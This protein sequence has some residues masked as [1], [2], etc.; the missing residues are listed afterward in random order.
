MAKTRAET[1]ERLRAGHDIRCSVATDVATWVLAEPSTMHRLA[2]EDEQWWNGDDEGEGPLAAALRAGRVVGVHTNADGT[3]HVR[4]T[5][6]SLT[7]REARV[8]SDE[9]TMRLVVEEG[10]L[11]LCDPSCYDDAAPERSE[12]VTIELDPGAYRVRLCA[13]AWNEDP[14][15]TTRSGARS[16]RSLADYVL[17][18]SRIERDEVLEGNSTLP[19]LAREPSLARRREQARLASEREAARDHLRSLTSSDRD[20]DLE[21]LLAAIEDEALRDT[22]VEAL[23]RASHHSAVD[24]MLRLLEAQGSP[25]RDLGLCDALLRALAPHRSAAAQ[26]IALQY[27]LTCPVGAGRVLLA[28]KDPEVLRRVAEALVDPSI[29]RAVAEVAV[30]AA[31][32]L[33]PNEA[34]DRIASA[35]SSTAIP[36]VSTIAIERAALERIAYTVERVDPRWKRLL[37][38]WFDAGQQD[39]ALVTLAVARVDG[40][41]GADTASLA[42][43]VLSAR[44]GGPKFDELCS[45][46]ETCGREPLASLARSA[47]AR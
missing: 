14:E 22:A 4:L 27:L 37:F 35:L 5:L 20:E 41:D 45:L 11:L 7:E 17:A 47:R 12:G 6:E 26:S 16:K 18:F 39:R 19:T 3:F 28:S 42:R 33:E 2:R 46:F 8:L 10:R 32:E 36:L 1:W 31:F 43:Q 29:P 34:F 23:G 15:S 21:T 9:V 24:R 13:L 38:R 44:T 30:A 40:V 25:P